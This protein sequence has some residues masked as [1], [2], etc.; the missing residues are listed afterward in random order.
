MATRAVS[1]SQKEALTN[2]LCWPNHP[3]VPTL[4]GPLGFCYG[5][6]HQ[7][8]S[9]C[10]TAAHG[11]MHLSKDHQEGGVE[12]P[13]RL[14]LSALTPSHQWCYVG[15]YASMS[16]KS[17]IYIFVCL[18]VIILHLI[19]CTAIHNCL[20]SGSLFFASL[21]WNNEK[22]SNRGNASSLDTVCWHVSKHRCLSCVLFCLLRCV[23]QCLT[24][25]KIL[26]WV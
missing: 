25:I 19:V 4:N 9:S 12:A 13:S 7:R 15:Q 20:S 26:H 2:C 16:I 11:H 18:G 6:Q 17:H 24:K 14:T 22:L 21:G 3:L 23:W 5:H 1:H 8:C 10:R